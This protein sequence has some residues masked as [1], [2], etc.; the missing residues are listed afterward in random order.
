MEDDLTKARGDFRWKIHKKSF[1]IKIHRLSPRRAF[2]VSLKI[3]TRE[4]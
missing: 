4:P 2:S 1:M 3:Y